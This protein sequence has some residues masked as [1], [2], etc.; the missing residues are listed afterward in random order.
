MPHGTADAQAYFPSDHGLRS[1]MAMMAGSCAETILFGDHD[2][3]GGSV[4]RQ[5]ARNRL[6]ALGYGDGAEAGLRA[7][8]LDRLRPCRTAIIRLAIELKRARALD[9]PTIDR[10]VDRFCR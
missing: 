8:T 5:R 9:G 4:D 7:H 1:V 6:R 2:R 10:L 3:D